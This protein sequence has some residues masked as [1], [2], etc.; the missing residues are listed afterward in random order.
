MST[1]PYI[2]IFSLLLVWFV[3]NTTEAQQDSIMEAFREQEVT[4]WSELLSRAQEH[5]TDSTIDVTFYH[6]DLHIAVDSNFISGSN[7]VTLMPVTDG[8]DHFFLDLQGALTVDSISFPC[9]DFSH[10]GNQLKINLDKPYDPGT[11][12]QLTIYYHGEPALANSIKGLVYEDH[13]GNEPV[14][15]TLSTPYLAHYWYPC[16]DG[17]ADKV[18]SVYVDI[19]IP[20]TAINGMD[21]IAVSNG[22]LNTTDLLDGKKTFRWRHTYPIVSYYVMAAVSNYATISDEYVSD[23]REVLPLDYYV[24]NESYQQSLEGV[25]GIPDA[26]ALFSE[27]F[28]EYPFMREKFGMTQ[29]GFYGAIENQTNVIQNVIHE[30]WF[31]VSVHELAHMWFGD[32]ITCESWHH[33]WLNEG[34]A[35]YCEALWVEHDQG[36]GAYRNYMDQFKYFGGGTLYLQNTDDPFSIFLPIIYRKGAWLLHMLR[37]VVGDELFFQTLKNYALHDDVRY[38]N[39]STQDFQYVAEDVSGLDLEYFFD[40]WVYDSYY[41]VYRYNYSQEGHT[42]Y[43]ALYQSQGENGWREFFEMPVQVRVWFEDE[44]DTTFTVRNDRTLQFFRFTVSK[45]VAWVETDPEE[46]I[47]RQSFYEPE[48]PVI[49][50]SERMTRDYRL[51]PNPVSTALHVAYERKSHDRMTFELYDLSGKKRFSTLLRDAYTTVDMSLF[52]PG[53]Y[54]YRIFSEGH[55]LPVTGKVLKIGNKE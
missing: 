11:P 31:L 7:R 47:L 3:V 12:L 1:G 54:F 17:P 28:G 9:I 15:A 40:Q 26:I 25:A 14:I 22:V 5:I 48:L 4:S 21:L 49:G 8:I 44:S 23:A 50:I 35:S 55:P 46:W 18:D 43:F 13:N 2:R 20:D 19:T 30:A 10:D 38:D 39:A 33:G 16:K 34:F 37:G 29:L 24:F 45:T 32:M 52:E 41:P 36:T 42:L 6:L 53:F 51:Y 27:R